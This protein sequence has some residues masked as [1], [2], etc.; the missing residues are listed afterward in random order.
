LLLL[1]NKYNVDK[2][3]A[4]CEVHLAKSLTVDT[5]LASLDTADR[6]A[7]GHLK[8]ACLKLVI[9]NIDALIQTPEWSTIMSPNAGLL[10][11]VMAE[12]LKK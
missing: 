11:V 10:S 12:S 4:F 2:L 1:A 5:V 8:E 7:A 9:D 3:V 6:V